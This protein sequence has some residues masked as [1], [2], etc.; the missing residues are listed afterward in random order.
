MVSC[1]PLPGKRS[2]CVLMS[3]AEERSFS[4]MCSVLPEAD[5]SAFTRLVFPACSTSL[6]EFAQYSNWR[7]GTYLAGTDD[8]EAHVEHRNV[9]A[10]EKLSN[11]RESVGPTAA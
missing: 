9:V 10:P 11:V 8:H 4:L 5:T 7:D 1:S 2:F 6:T 3:R